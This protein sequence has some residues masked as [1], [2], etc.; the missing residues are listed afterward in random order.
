M[1]VTVVRIGFPLFGGP[2]IKIRIFIILII[3]TM[4]E[5][6]VLVEVL[7]KLMGIEVALLHK[8]TIAA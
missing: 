8:M 2:K 3:C 1:E 4:A 6:A 7:K 5:L